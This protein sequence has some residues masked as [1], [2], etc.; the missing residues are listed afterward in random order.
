MYRM[1]GIFDDFE[2]EITGN[3]Q[4]GPFR[5]IGKYRSWIGEFKNSKRAGKWT[6]HNSIKNV[7]KTMVYEDGKLEGLFELVSPNKIVRVNYSNNKMHGTYI[8]HN[9]KRGTSV[10]GHFEHGY[11][12][13]RWTK[14]KALN[15]EILFDLNYRIQTTKFGTSESVL[16]GLYMDRYYIG[17]YD[18]GVRVGRWVS[19]DDSEIIWY[20]G[21]GLSNH[22][23]K[24]KV[25]T[26]YQKLGGVCHGFYI[27]NPLMENQNVSYY[28]IGRLVKVPDHLKLEKKDDT[29]SLTFVN[30]FDAIET[31]KFEA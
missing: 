22:L 23:V 27:T 30:E 4:E 6:Y 16:H 18:F 19:R 1:N 3:Q 7:T 10:I 28:H 2:A 15:D 5:A 9:F 17:Q 8:K 21:T 26:L 14:K 31:I 11:H 12:I 24:H 20:S 13:G 25:I 29:F